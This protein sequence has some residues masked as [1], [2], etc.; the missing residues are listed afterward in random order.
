MSYS[1]NLLMLSE[2][3]NMILKQIADN[4]YVNTIGI[5]FIVGLLLV[6]IVVGV[7]RL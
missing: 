3:G 4:Q 5:G 1:D 7:I 2:S 6:I